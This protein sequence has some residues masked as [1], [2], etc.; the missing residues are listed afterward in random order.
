MVLV[1]F[2][3]KE[4]SQDFM[5]VPTDENTIVKEDMESPHFAASKKDWKK[6]LFR[7]L[8]GTTS[9]EIERKNA[10][11]RFKEHNTSIKTRSPI[12]TIA[13]GLI[14]GE[15][16]EKGSR[17]QAGSV[18]KTAYDDITDQVFLVSAGGQLWKGGLEGLSWEIVNQKARFQENFLE[19]VY[20]ADETRRIVAIIN[21]IPHYSD[22]DGLTWT[23]N[24]NIAEF[25]IIK[26]AFMVLDGSQRIYLLARVPGDNKISVYESA[27]LGETYIK[28]YSLITND[29]N[30]VSMAH[31]RKTD[32]L[33]IIEN[34][35]STSRIYKF[36][37]DKSSVD[38]LE[39]FADVSFDGRRAKLVASANDLG[40]PYLYILS[41]KNGISTYLS[42]D[43]GTTWTQQGILPS[44]PWGVGI[45]VSSENP[46]YLMY[47]DI[48]CYRSFDGGLT[49][50]VIN[51]WGEYYSDVT[52]K[53][54]ADMMW[55]SD[56]VDK[57]TDEYFMLISN[58]GGISKMYDYDQQPTNFS[59][60]G[61][62]VSQYY[63]VRTTPGT[64]EFVYAGSQ[65]QGFQ[66]GKDVPDE[67]L[68]LGQAISG[69][70]GHI[71]FTT[72]GKLWTVYP[73]GWVSFWPDPENAGIALNYEINS[74]DESVWIPPLA[75]APNDYIDQIY[76]AGGNIN[77]GSGSHIVKLNATESEIQV[78]QLDFDFR[79][80][81]GGVVSSIAIAD[82]VEENIYAAT[83]N[84][85]F[86][87]SN[88]FGETFT[89]AQ[90]VPGGHYLYGQAIIPSKL[91][92]NKVYTGGNGYNG[93]PVMR[94]IDGGKT[95][96][97]F[98]DGLPATVVLGMAMN[99]DESL[100][101]A[102]TTSGPF[103][104][105]LSDYKWYDMSGEAAPDVIYWSVEL[106][107]NGLT[108][109]FG[110][111]GRGIWDFTISEF[112][113]TDEN[114]VPLLA[115]A[116]IYP[117]PAITSFVVEWPANSSNASLLSMDG[118]KI[119]DIII[120]GRQTE[121][122]MESLPAGQYILKFNVHEQT[123]SQIIIKQ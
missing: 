2:G 49:W 69:D 10:F 85:Q 38:L 61:L 91:N 6:K 76:M 24:E 63:S 120:D 114:E 19:I 48:E 16:L 102:A 65:D 86:Y 121:V 34:L 71:Q 1:F 72:T 80:A 81:S 92:L 117:N 119:K 60:I 47:G 33:Y 36:S 74:D 23:A 4:Q 116:K 77:G 13:D 42:T 11:A 95:F 25:N 113:G 109:R 26:D 50:E 18:F 45:F 94:S 12:E 55:F 75:V 17:N 100:L 88:D 105:V 53:L 70:Y 7:T 99:E 52:N 112:V 44:S 39:S 101:F 27:D 20:K 58:H 21:R 67:I 14:M 68:D 83:D 98:S 54:H 29:A 104:C 57:D 30:L 87:Y 115:E 84:G 96:E 51:T 73:G 90:N 122:N 5:P 8:D 41:N 22:D 64:E 15:W 89:K 93:V 108:A 62:N 3:C 46:N 82:E 32:D 78:S 31:A 118:G 97:N 66:R 9:E 59:L 43:E 106:I 35:S 103:V 40:E 110:T 79:A 111:Y 37:E 28:K 123:Q 56:Y 107:N